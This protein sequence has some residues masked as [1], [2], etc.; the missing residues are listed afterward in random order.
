MEKIQIDFKQERDF[1]EIFNATFGFI[2]QEFKL[3]GRAVL[4]FVL[5]I[6][7]VAA[8]IVV[9]IGMEQQ[10]S[11]NTFQTGGLYNSDPISTIGSTFKYTLL[12]LLMYII[13]ITVLRCTIYGYIKLYVTK[14][15]DQF[16]L[17]DVWGEIKKFFF[18]VLGTSLVIG[19]ITGIGFVFCLVPGIYL[20]VSLCVIYISLMFEDEG[21]S[22]AFGRSFDLTKQRWWLTFAILLICYIIIYIIY[23]LCSLPAMLLVGFKSFFMASK[24][25]YNSSELN[26]TVYYIISSIAYL[27]LYILFS[28]PFTATAFQYFSLRE[29]KERPSLQ[30]KI[31]QI[32]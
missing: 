11:L 14:G 19:L 15:K 32:A 5:P 3:L 18:P 28:I 9:L 2:G 16:N 22:N 12:T 24:G 27:I 23:I 4:Y 6:L 26:L 1:G 31:D 10:K 17:N 8:V 30:E 29:I 25:T 13:A 7:I 20:G 21:F